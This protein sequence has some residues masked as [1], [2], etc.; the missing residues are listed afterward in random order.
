MFPSENQRNEHAGQAIK[1]REPN[2]ARLVREYNKICDQISK[3]IKTNKA[4]RGAVAPI[5]VPAKGIYQLDVDDVIWQDLGLDEDQQGTPPL[6]LSN[7]NVRSGIR[8]LLQ[9]DRCQEEAPQL[10]RERGHLQTWFAT[11]WK[12]VC[13]AIE[14]SDGTLND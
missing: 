10:L 5:P 1:R 2:I 7:D 3:L 9:K 11:E 12:A 8:A 4:P 14:L 13:E 6:W